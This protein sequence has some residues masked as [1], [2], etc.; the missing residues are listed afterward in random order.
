MKVSVLVPVYRAE[1]YIAQ[2]VK[3]L[4]GQTYKDIDYVFLD[5]CSPDKSMEVLERVALEYPQRSS[6]ITIIR[7]KSNQGVANARN[8]LLQYADGDYIYFVDSDDYIDL[9]AIERLARIAEETSSDIVRQNYY[10]VLENKCIKKIN[11]PFNSKEQL[12]FNTIVGSDGVEGMPLL[13]IKRT[14]FAD[15]NLYFDSAVSICEDYVMSVKLFFFA[16]KVVDI[17]DAFYYYRMEGNSDSL[18]KNISF[19]LNDRIEAVRL[20]KDFLVVKRNIST[21]QEAILLRMMRCKQA[22]LINRNYLDL[23]KYQS[24]FPEANKV[25][26]KV[27]FSLREKLLFWLAEKK[28]YFLIKTLYFRF[29][30]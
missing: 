9:F 12:L 30:Q 24:T 19:L 25:W 11:P 26:R 5:D 16:K 28:M 8:L 22:F 18:T 4:L 2:C 14:L 3:S 13:F 17:T 29:K 6:H 1:K 15:N 23:K 20:V 10:E 27:G 7:N 21:Y